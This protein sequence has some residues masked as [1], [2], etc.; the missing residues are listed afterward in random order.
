MVVV[1]RAG[2]VIPQVVA[3]LT[4]LRTGAERPF[5]M[6][7]RCPVCGTPVVRT[8]G[9]VAVRCPNLECPARRLEA[10]KHFVSKG[11]MDI[12]GVGDKLVERLLE[13]GMI[14]D[15]ADLYG[16]EQTSL[17]ELDRRSETP[18]CPREGQARAFL[19]RARGRFL[20]RLRRIAGQCLLQADRCRTVR[21][22]E[23]ES[24]IGGQ[25]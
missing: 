19:P 2:D 5:R 9:E 20:A 17:A 24:R 14:A 7:D 16:L 4:D 15:A 12:D 11:A 10:L 23:S 6:P 21:P 8:P 1:Q 22:V 25:A 13:L 3:P 18:S